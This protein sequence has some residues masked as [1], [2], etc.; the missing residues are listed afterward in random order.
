[1]IIRKRFASPL[2]KGL[3]ARFCATPMAFPEQHDQAHYLLIFLRSK[4]LL[5]PAKPS[6]DSLHRLLCLFGGWRRREIDF[7]QH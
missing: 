1:L 7:D 5:K 6:V 2:F 4:S 3:A